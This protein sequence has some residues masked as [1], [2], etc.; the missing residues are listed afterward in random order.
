MLQHP[1][2]IC[3]PNLATSVKT[4]NINKKRSTRILRRR[5]SNEPK[6][7]LPIARLRAP[8]NAR[9]PKFMELLLCFGEIIV[10]HVTVMK[11]PRKIFFFGFIWGP[12][13]PHKIDKKC[14]R[15]AQGVDFTKKFWGV[16]GLSSR[17]VV[18]RVNALTEFLW[19]LSQEPRNAKFR[20][21]DYLLR[22]WHPRVHIFYQYIYY[23]SSGV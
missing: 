3:F 4:S 16:Q 10:Q 11:L 17:N 19:V 14:T 9:K 22:N 12:R 2:W 7:A 21:R 15:F 5:A 8:C 18:P 20:V 23:Q 13:T 6:R 1:N